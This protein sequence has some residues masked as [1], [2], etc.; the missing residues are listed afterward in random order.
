MNLYSIQDIKTGFLHP[1]LSDNDNSATRAFDSMLGSDQMMSKY[2]NDFRLFRIGE[3][4]PVNAAIIPCV[5]TVH[6]VDAASILRGNDN[7]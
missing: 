6:I 4:N 3:F 2:P 5:P 1:W 7:G